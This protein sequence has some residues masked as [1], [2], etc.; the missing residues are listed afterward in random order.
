MIT[1]MMQVRLVGEIFALGIYEPMEDILA[2]D[3]NS[4][5]SQEMT[6]TLEM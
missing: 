5:P 4:M 3:G 2:R 6:R 1:K